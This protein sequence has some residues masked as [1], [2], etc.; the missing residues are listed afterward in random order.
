MEQM[1]EIGET[2]RPN[3]LS[4][5]TPEGNVPVNNSPSLSLYGQKYSEMAIMDS[6]V[7]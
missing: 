4:G 7:N 2:R 6:I 1:E 5:S 3:T